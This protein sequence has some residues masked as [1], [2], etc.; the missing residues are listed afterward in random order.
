[1]SLL[2]SGHR[3]GENRRIT[4]FRIALFWSTVALAVG[5]V[6]MVALGISKPDQLIPAAVG[7]GYAGTAYF[8]TGRRPESVVGWTIGLIGLVVVIG[9]ATNG[10]LEGGHAETGPLIVW[11]VVAQ[12]SS[13]AW[14]L[15]LPGLVAIALPLLFPDG[16]LPSA[17]WRWVAW[18]GIGGTAVG[19]ITTTLQPGLIDVVPPVE[20]PIGVVDLSLLDQLASFATTFAMLGAFAAL[21]VRLRRSCGVERQQLKWFAYVLTVIIV[22]FSVAGV[23]SSIGSDVFNVLGPIFWFTALTMIAVGIPL[24]TAFAVLKHRLYDID[25]VIRRTLIYATLTATL[26]GA[27]VG[28]VLLLQFVLSP[29]SD[30]AVAGSTLAVAAL[31]R[32]ALA[33]IQGAVNRRFYR[34][35]YDATHTVEIFGAR[36]RDELSLDALSDELRTVVTDTMQPA[37]VSLWLR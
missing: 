36:L 23:A 27:Y 5:I 33:R 35:A 34:S 21:I 19:M 25:V 22:A 3:R 15:W 1:V 18:L 8:L 6:V 16:R 11:Q 30:L 31:F 12:L 28:S 9:G 10:Y 7:A 17:R 29:S 32:P 37:H 14:N 24:A 20:N 13:F 2:A 26:G 4:G